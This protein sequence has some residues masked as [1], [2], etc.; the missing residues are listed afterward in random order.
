MKLRVIKI[1]RDEFGLRKIYGKSLKSYKTSQLC[2][3][4]DVLRR[5]DS[6]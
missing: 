2:A 3:F 6:L 4:V 5:G 1:L